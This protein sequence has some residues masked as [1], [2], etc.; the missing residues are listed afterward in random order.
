MDTVAEWIEEEETEPDIQV[1]SE[2]LEIVEKA[3]RARQKMD[4]LKLRL[5]EAES[6]LNQVN[7]QVL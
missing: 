4:K 2:R 3:E 6:T 7:N 1:L 5:E